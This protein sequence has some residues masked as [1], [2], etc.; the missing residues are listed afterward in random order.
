MSLPDTAQDGR[1]EVPYSRGLQLK[2]DKRDH[3]RDR[4]GNGLWLSLVGMSVVE[5]EKHSV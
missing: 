4:V 2:R 1:R 5:I 3:I